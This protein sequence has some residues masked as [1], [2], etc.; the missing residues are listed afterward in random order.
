MKTNPELY[1][2]ILNLPEADFELELAAMSPEMQ[3]QYSRARLAR[4]TVG[5][6]P[7]HL[8]GFAAKVELVRKAQDNIG[9]PRAVEDVKKQDRRG[10]PRFHAGRPSKYETPV[11]TDVISIRC[12]R[13][14]AVRFRDMKK[15]FGASGCDLFHHARHLLLDYQQHCLNIGKPTGH[16]GLMLYHSLK[17]GNLFKANVRTIPVTSLEETKDDL[18]IE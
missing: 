9:S 16:E 14:D 10:G 8:K 12:Y 7:S 13:S 18:T 3:V 5:V 1:D 4:S 17:T 11:E 15:S 6:P 2:D